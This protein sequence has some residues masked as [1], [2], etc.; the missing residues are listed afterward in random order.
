MSETEPATVLGGITDSSRRTFIKQ[1]AFSAIALG[2][3]TAADALPLPSDGTRDPQTS[4][5]RPNIVLICADQFRADF[6]GAYG[7]NP[8]TV[9]P[10]LD[11]M[12]RRG[13]AF[14]QAVTNNPLCSPSRGCMITGRY[15]LETG[16]W[17]LAQELRRDLPTLAGA[18]R[19]DGYTT[20]FIGKWHLAKYD[21]ATGVGAGAVLPEDRGGFLDLWEGANEFELTT[22]P[23]KG[24]IWDRDGKPIEFEN[25]YRIDFITDR[26]VRFL[27][28]PQEKPFL[29][30][31][32]HLEPHTQNDLDRP[33]APN[34]VAEKFQNPFVPADLLHLPGTWQAQL[35]DYY[36]CVQS[37]DQSVGKIIA[38]LK[39]E[40]LLENTIVIFISDHG[41]HFKTRNLHYK[42]SPH[43]SSIRI[44]FVFQ[45][46]GF[47]HCLQLNE[48]VSMIDLTPTIL[49]AAKV[50][51]P[52]SMKGRDLAPLLT[53][54]EARRAW[55][56]TAYIQ[57]NS[58]EVARALRTEQW[59]YCVAD[60]NASGET[61]PA[62][63]HYQEHLMYNLYA[64]PAQHVNLAGRKE[65]TDVAEKLRAELKRR[66]VIAGENAAEIKPARVVT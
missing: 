20:N 25:Q 58:T 16:E 11:G 36:G 21:F 54:P 65:Y 34:G 27:R 23:Y 64:D 29:L 45:G 47:D 63:D 41:C 44:P 39:E 9:T 66:M 28:Q 52:A 18:L 6:I 35:P 7:E 50:A 17:K 43:D 22:H 37:I 46:P 33:V 48:V 55:D 19:D 59:C 40:N 49:S 32:S 62:S 15:A 26:A 42:Q 2:S 60:L 57:I 38:T 8:T 12:V 51:I 53:N 3:P 61:V 56:N 13:I 24:T 31:I 10:N 1:S 30:Y 5:K 4:Q 14:K